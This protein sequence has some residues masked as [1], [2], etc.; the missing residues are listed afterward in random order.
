MV[1]KSPRPKKIGVVGFACACV[2]KFVAYAL[3]CSPGPGSPWFTL[4][5]SIAAKS[6]PKGFSVA[7]GG[8]HRT[9]S[10]E[11]I[12]ASGVS[13]DGF[14]LQPLERLATH[15]KVADSRPDNVRLPKDDAIELETWCDP[16]HYVTEGRISYRQG[17][18]GPSWSRHVD[19]DLT[20]V[21]HL[22]STRPWWGGGAASGDLYVDRKPPLD[23]F[24]AM[25]AE[26]IADG[27]EPGSPRRRA[28]WSR[29]EGG[30]MSIPLMDLV[31]IPYSESRRS[32]FPESITAPSPPPPR[33]FKVFLDC[34]PNRSIAKVTLAY[35]LN[36]SYDPHA[37]AKG[38][39]ACARFS[40]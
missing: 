27:K 8:V 24:C 10:R 5:I 1:F 28:I 4:K 21:G 19:L 37:F 25:S 39:E 9:G 34:Y 32:N 14:Q 18:P 40:R 16:E 7:H 30:T 33:S 11:C 26:N 31:G 20:S 15:N 35:T 17:V 29:G 6:L 22:I 36:K 3:A 2:L 12:F 23:R 38:I 13:L